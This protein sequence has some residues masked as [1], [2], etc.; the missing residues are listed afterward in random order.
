MPSLLHKQQQLAILIDAENAS[1][2]LTGAVIRRAACYG[3]LAVRRA[4]GDWS[5]PQLHRHQHVL[6]MHAAQPVQ[7][8]PLATGKNAADMVLTIEAMDLLGTGMLDG[9]CLVTSDCDFTHLAMRYRQEG[10]RVY[11]FGRRHT[12]QSFVQACTRFI[13]VE[14]LGW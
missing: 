9:V 12:P 8:F 11:G 4:Y 1:Q 5:R 3:V 10:L 6:R 2:T 13:Y 14:D 7:L